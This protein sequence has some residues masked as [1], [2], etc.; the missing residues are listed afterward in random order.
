MKTLLTLILTCVSLCTY[1]QKHHFGTYFTTKKDISFESGIFEFQEDNT[2]NY[3][4]FNCTGI[5][6]GKGKYKI[7][8]DDSLQLQF[9]NCTYNTLND[10]EMIEGSGDS[11]Q[12]NLMIKE[13]ESDHRLPGTNVSCKNEKIGVVTNESG[14]AKFT[15]GNTKNDKVLLIQ[16]I[17]YEPIQIKISKDI[18]EVNGTIHLSNFWFYD[19]T[20]IKTYKITKWSKSKLKLER[21]PN[22]VITYDRVHYKKIENLIT[23]RIGE[24]GIK[25]Y[26]NMK[27]K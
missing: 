13:F 10:V 6:F 15:I 7:T 9:M 22:E 26:T 27:N 19:S 1:G 12:I 14:E 4:F 21:Y 5:G 17:G 20:D 25:L 2:F 11:L 3:V 16:S 23:N 8:E 18:R 24:K